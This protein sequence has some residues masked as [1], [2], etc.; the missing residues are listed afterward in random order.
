MELTTSKKLIHYRVLI[1]NISS[2]AKKQGQKYHHVEEHEGG[3]NGMKCN[4]DSC[5]PWR[6]DNSCH[7]MLR[8]IGACF[9]E[10]LLVEPTKQ[11]TPD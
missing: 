9:T 4:N 2:T 7:L 1:L 5:S 11:E 6:L 10:P 8:L 3:Y